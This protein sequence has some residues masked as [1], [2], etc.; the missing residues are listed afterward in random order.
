MRRYLLPLAFIFLM[1]FNEQAAYREIDNRSFDLGK[2]DD[3]MN[4]YITRDM[5]SKSIDPIE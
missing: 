3:A 4:T 1:A 5:L 2:G